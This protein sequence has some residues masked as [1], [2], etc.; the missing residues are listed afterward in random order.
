MSGAQPRTFWQS[1]AAV[2]VAL[3]LVAGSVATSRDSLAQPLPKDPRAQKKGPPAKGPMQMRKGPMGQAVAPG[4]MGPR[5]RMLG[6]Q[7]PQGAQAGPQ[8]SPNMRG[9]G[10]RD[11]RT[12]A[13]NKGPNARFGNQGFGGQQGRFGGQQGRFGNQQGRF[14]QPRGFTFRDPRMRAVNGATPQVRQTQRFSHRNEMFALRARLPIFPLPGE[15]NFTGVPPVTETRF[16]ELVPSGL[17][18]K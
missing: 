6:P 4:P 17:R 13:F 11:P 18:L 14:G 9:P 2:A 12:N 1:A 16:V 10:F 5:G 7:G 15:R 3:L 8:V